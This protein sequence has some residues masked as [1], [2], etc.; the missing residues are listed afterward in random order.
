MNE[1]IEKLKAALKELMEVAEPFTD[2]DVVDETDGTIPLMTRL[3][4]ALEAADDVL[5]E[6][7]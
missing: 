4:K 5:G 1:T 6:C 3:D 2:S 7:E